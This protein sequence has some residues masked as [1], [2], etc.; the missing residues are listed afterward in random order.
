ML[1]FPKGGLKEGLGKGLGGFG[2]HISKSLF[3]NA[4]NVLYKHHRNTKCFLSL[5][6]NLLKFKVIGQ[7]VNF[8]QTTQA[9]RQSLSMISWEELSRRNLGADGTSECKY[10]LLSCWLDLPVRVWSMSSL[11]LAG[12]EREPARLDSKSKSTHN[13]VKGLV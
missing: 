3:E 11:T 4:S 9:M 6:Q 2:F 7:T 13:V 5:V 12:S 10:L 8:I 1:F